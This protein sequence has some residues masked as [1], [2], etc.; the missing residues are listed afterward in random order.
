MYGLAPPIANMCCRFCY[1]SEDNDPSPEYEEYL[2]CSVCGDNGTLQRVSALNFIV[3]VTEWKNRG[4]AT[5]DS[6][7]RVQALTFVPAAHR[8]CARSAGS[9]A[10]DEGT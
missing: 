1:Q 6:K 8:Q 5:N 7:S 4:K 10:S 9:L 3:D 2:A